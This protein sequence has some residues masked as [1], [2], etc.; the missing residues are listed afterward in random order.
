VTMSLMLKRIFDCAAALIGLLLL[1]PLLFCVA[2][3]VRAAMG[4]PVFF[5]HERPGHKGRAFKLHKFRT[6]T[7][8]RGA[9][10]VLL[11]D[12]KRITDSGSRLRKM[13]LDELPQLWNVL[14]GEMS[15]VG[16]RPLLKEYLPLYNEEQSRRHDVRPGIT[17]W[18]Q[19]N[20]RNALTWEEKFDLDVWYVDNCSIWLDLKILCLTLGSVMRGRGVAAPGHASMPKFTGAS[21]PNKNGDQRN[22]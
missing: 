17:G 14:K 8:E 1:S 4:A 16:P 22:E 19:V 9:D 12:E 7:N 20:G 21:I 6:L 13:S 15:F 5:T 10:G 11:P 3:I 18:A 2:L